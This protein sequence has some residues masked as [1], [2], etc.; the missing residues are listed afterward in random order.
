M[1]VITNTNIIVDD[2]GYCK[3]FKK[4]TFV[5]FLTHF[6][7]DHWDGLTPLWDYSNIYCT[8][9]TAK[10]IINKFPKLSHLVIPC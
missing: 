3:S 2:F 5:H 8:N 4:N 10:L 1:R 9:T 7:Q 6:H